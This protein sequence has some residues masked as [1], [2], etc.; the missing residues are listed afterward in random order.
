MNKVIMPAQK[1]AQTNSNY[2]KAEEIANS[3]SH[4]LGALLSCL[5]LFLLLQKTSPTNLT[6]DENVRF[7]SFSVFGIS[8]TLLF[9]LQPSIT[10]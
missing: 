2:S 9:L 4:G 3:L 1:L 7:I 6:T 5:A 8:L 10:A